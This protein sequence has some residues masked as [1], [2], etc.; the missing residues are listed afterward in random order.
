MRG[1]TG[2]FEASASDKIVSALVVCAWRTVRALGVPVLV[3]GGFDRAASEHSLDE[4]SET[5]NVERVWVTVTG[6]AVNT[7]ASSES[8]RESASSSVTCVSML[9]TMMMMKSSLEQRHMITMPLPC[10]DMSE[11]TTSHIRDSKREER[12]GAAEEEGRTHL[13]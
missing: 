9:S 10:L 4:Q 7:T 3:L 2:E 11:L 1:G 13:A 6:L 5:V 12:G 8:V